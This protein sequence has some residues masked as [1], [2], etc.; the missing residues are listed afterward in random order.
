VLPFIKAKNK[1]DVERALVNLQKEE[2]I[3]KTIEVSISI[4]GTFFS[5]IFIC[6][7]LEVSD[8]L[9]QNSG[10]GYDHFQTFCWSYETETGGSKL[11]EMRMNSL[12]V[13]EKRFA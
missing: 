7:K 1:K 13:W 4:E 3:K 8:Y 9:S 12:L 11:R 10:N 5:F 6:K 2:I